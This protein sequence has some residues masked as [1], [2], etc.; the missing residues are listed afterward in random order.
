M[1]SEVAL[2]LQDRLNNI[3]AFLVSFHA[4]PKALVDETVGALNLLGFRNFATLTVNNLNI[5]QQSV[6]SFTTS[7]QFFGRDL[8]KVISGDILA[9]LARSNAPV[10]RPAGRILLS[11]PFDQVF[12]RE[13]DQAYFA[14]YSVF[15]DKYTRGYCVIFG[16][17][18]ER[19]QSALWSLQPIVQLSVETTVKIPNTSSESKPLKPRE[20][21]ALRWTHQHKT[22]AE[23]AQVMDMPLRQ[24]NYHI[25]LSIKKLGAKNKGHAAQL[26]HEMGL[27]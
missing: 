25:T 7:D 15:R 23:V 2:G 26:A 16:S 8:S 13:D 3:A 10:I 4:Q 11:A 14:V 5:V 1:H 6:S 12:T 17:S 21:E 22:S 9:D 27:F 20:I 24:V 19:L 18:A